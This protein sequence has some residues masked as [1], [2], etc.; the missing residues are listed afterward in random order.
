[1]VVSSQPRRAPKS[2]S[3]CV[4][5]LPPLLLNIETFQRSNLP[6]RFV[7]SPLALS[8]SLDALCHKSVHQLFFH[9]SLT[10]SFLKMPGCTAFFSKI[11]TNVCSLSKQKSHN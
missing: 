1:M 5:P 6:T 9:Q 11:C 4:L 10:H 8:H 2:C 7:L 3:L